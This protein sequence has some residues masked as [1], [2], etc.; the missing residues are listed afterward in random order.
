MMNGMTQPT[1]PDRKAAMSSAPVSTRRIPVKRIV[2]E[3]LE[4]E[5]GNL[6]IG[7][8]TT[9]TEAENIILRICAMAPKDGSY[10]KTRFVVTWLD[11]EQYSGRADL[12][13]PTSKAY[14]GGLAKH[15]RDYCTFLCGLRRPGHLSDAE[16]SGQLDT[17]YQRDPK[18][19]ETALKFL[20][21]YALSDDAGCVTPTD[22]SGPIATINTA[23]M[24]SDVVPPTPQPLK[25]PTMDTTTSTQPAPK[26]TAREAHDENVRLNDGKPLVVITGNTFP[27]KGVLYAFGGKYD[28]ATKT[29]NVPAHKAQEAQA[30]ADRFAPKPKATTAP[31]AAPVSTAPAVSITT[32][33]VK[34][35]AVKD[36]AKPRP[37]SGSKAK[38]TSLEA[39]I[40]FVLKGLE[41]IAVDAKGTS[42]EA[43]LSAAINALKGV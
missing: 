16:Y 33:Q 5:V 36:T 9:W 35:A 38:P 37:V 12:T 43:A 26:Q 20:T 23:P 7:D 1:N 39:R 27:I 2:I 14:E 10:W 31:K 15:I 24:M 30:A 17:I 18:I 6:H 29:W 3:Q 34:A 40:Q 8:V 4:G 11:G 21:T 13:H 28:A 41:H 19:K 42:A 22:L 25:G 32:A